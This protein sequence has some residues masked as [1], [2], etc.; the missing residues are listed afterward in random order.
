MRLFAKARTCR[1]SV[2]Q[3]ARRRPLARGYPA[4]SQV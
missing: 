4:E 3:D 2:R 1:A